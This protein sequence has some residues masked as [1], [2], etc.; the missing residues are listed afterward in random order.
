[1]WVGL[2]GGLHG[3]DCMVLLLLGGNFYFCEVET[4]TVLR[5]DFSMQDAG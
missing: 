3:L 2:A 4:S 5:G 1:M